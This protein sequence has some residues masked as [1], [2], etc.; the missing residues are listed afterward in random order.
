MFSKEIRNEYICVYRLRSVRIRY[1]TAQHKAV[2]I[3]LHEFLGVILVL[4][5]KDQ[6]LGMTE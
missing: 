5:G 3:I 4:P 6:V 2:L 1:G